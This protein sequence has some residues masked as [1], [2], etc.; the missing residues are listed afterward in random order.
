MN[1]QVGTKSHFFEGGNLVTVIGVPILVGC[2]LY[3]YQKIGCYIR[4]YEISVPDVYSYIFN[5]FAIELGALLTLFALFACKPTPFLERMKNTASFRAIIANVNVTLAIS[6]FALAMTFVFGL[7]KIQPDVKLTPNSYL[8]LSW[9]AVV[10]TT[11]CIYARTV[12]L[13]LTTLN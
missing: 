8:Y 10:V 6:I 11:C 3:F 2:T 13:I 12:R 7:L 5:L 4:P 9:C 1:T